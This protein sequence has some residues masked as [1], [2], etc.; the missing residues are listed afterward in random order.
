M[1]DVLGQ[2]T[3]IKMAFK[4]FR[5]PIRYFVYFTNYCC[6]FILLYN[7]RVELKLFPNQTR[8]INHEITIPEEL[9]RRRKPIA[10]FPE[11]LTFPYKID[12]PVNQTKLIFGFS[13]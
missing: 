12:E 9:V 1:S 10:G 5:I 4:V 7:I 3:F 11:N 6:I 8:E 2:K 13:G